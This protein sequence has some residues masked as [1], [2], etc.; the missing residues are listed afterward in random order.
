M[1]LSVSRVNIAC[2]LSSPSGASGT[3]V[4]LFLGVQ[5]VSGAKRC[6]PSSKCGSPACTEAVGHVRVVPYCV[7]VLRFSAS[8]PTW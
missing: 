7:H 5:S 1:A 8:F 4:E 6:F 3:A 2:A